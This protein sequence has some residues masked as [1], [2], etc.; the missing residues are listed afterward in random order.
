MYLGAMKLLAWI[1][2][3]LRRPALNSQ[4]ASTHTVQPVAVA[5]AIT[6]PVDRPTPPPALLAPPTEAEQLARAGQQQAYIMEVLAQSEA[7][8]LT[9]VRGLPQKLQRLLLTQSLAQADLA[10]ARAAKWWSEELRLQLEVQQLEAAIQYEAWQ[11]ALV[12]DHGEE[13]G[14]KLAQHQVEAGMTLKHLFASYGEPPVGGITYDSEDPDLWFIQY[15]SAATGSY[16]EQRDGII[17]LA[18]LGMPE[19]PN[20]VRDNMR[21]V[22]G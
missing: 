5:A 16:F 2:A 20:Y 14:R 21:E 9:A 13:I 1:L 3:R 18:R 6:V 22:G 19:L 12:T 10:T 11:H 15:G 4:Q 7:L 8:G 17:T